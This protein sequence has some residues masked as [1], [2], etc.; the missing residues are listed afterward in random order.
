M[1]FIGNIKWEIF[2]RDFVGAFMFTL[3]LYLLQ[4]RFPK[5]I[6]LEAFVIR[7]PVNGGTESE[8]MTNEWTVS[9][10]NFNV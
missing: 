10:Y 8:V 6:Q 4:K 7:T 5:V 1:E 9:I 3:Q 2:C